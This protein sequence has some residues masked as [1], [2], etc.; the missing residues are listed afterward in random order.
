MNVAIMLLGMLA[1]QDELDVLRKRIETLE[2]RVS[3]QDAKIRKLEKMIAEILKKP[4]VKIPKLKV[5]RK[6]AN[7]EL[8]GQLRRLNEQIR[9][10]PRSSATVR[11]DRKRTRFQ[12][13]PH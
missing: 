8:E 3:A 6:L 13:R 2:S 11:I 5:D 10:M 12:V 4:V 7:K 1:Q 9:E